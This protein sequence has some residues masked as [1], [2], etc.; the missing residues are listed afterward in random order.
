MFSNLAWNEKRIVAIGLK[1]GSWIKVSA[2]KNSFQ[3]ARPIIKPAVSITGQDK[4]N[5]ILKKIWKVF[6]PSNLAA[7][8]NSSGNLII[9][10]LIKKVAKGAFKAE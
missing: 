3:T 9:Y 2:N 1:F 4:G 10:D 5:A 8:N 6:A 7:S